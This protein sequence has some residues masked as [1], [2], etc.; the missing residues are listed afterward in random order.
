MQENELMGSMKVSKAVA[1]NG[2][3]ECDQQSCDGC[4]QYGGHVFL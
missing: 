1:K 2:D 3:T 4:I